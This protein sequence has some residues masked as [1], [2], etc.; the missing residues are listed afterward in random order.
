MSNWYNVV[1]GEDTPLADTLQ[2]M[3]QSGLQIGLVVDAHG[4]LNGVVTDGDIR[5]ALLHGRGIAASTGEVMNGTPLALPTGTSRQDILTFMRAHSIQQVPLVDGEGKLV[6]LATIHA[7]IGALEQENWVVLM[8]GGLGMRL[9]PL[10][11]TCPKPLL[12]VGGKPILET[13]LENFVEQ[14]FRRFFIA[15]NYK[16]EMIR[17]HFGDGKRWG[18]RIDY[19]EESIPLG[20]AGALTL[21]PEKPTAPVIAMNGDLLT[22]PNFST[23]LDFHENRGALATMAV[24]EFDYQVPYGVVRLDGDYIAGIEEKPVQR[25]YVNAGI[26]VIS[27]EALATIPD[28][29]SYDMPTL[30]QDLNQRGAQTAAFPL[31][32]YW[33]DIGRIEEFER[34]QREWPVELGGA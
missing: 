11:E 24:R 4:R 1:V 22:R 20:T 23:L 7:L 27:P 5:R 10:T 17:Q 12:P 13:I 6:D 25:F 15:V 2:R 26:Y 31:Q 3:D 30:F 19:V 14:G 32:D 29:R 34:A 16:A 21:L 28:D 33:L 9:R 18:I 8:A